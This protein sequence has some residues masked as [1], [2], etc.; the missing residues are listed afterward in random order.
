MFGV[1]FDVRE[2]PELSEHLVTL[3]RRL[4]RAATAG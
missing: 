2:P 1:D 3:A 4:E